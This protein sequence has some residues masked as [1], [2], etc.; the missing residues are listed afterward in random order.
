[1]VFRVPEFQNF[2]DQNDPMDSYSNRLGNSYPSFLDF[3]LAK[4]DPTKSRLWHRNPCA[5]HNSLFLHTEADVHS[6]AT[7]GRNVRCPKFLP[8]CSAMVYPL[9]PC[10]VE[11]VLMVWAEALVVTMVVWKSVAKEDAQEELSLDSWVAEVD[12]VIHD[13]A[14]KSLRLWIIWMVRSSSL[15]RSLRFRVDDNHG[16]LA[17]PFRLSRCFG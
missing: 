8:N 7:I 4:H 5:C 9:H 3:V 16:P 14:S 11:S 6:P 15:K 10:L 13:S 2:H 12:S 1:M 17:A